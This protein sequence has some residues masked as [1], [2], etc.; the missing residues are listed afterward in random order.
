MSNSQEENDGTSLNNRRGFIFDHLWGIPGDVDL[1]RLKEFLSM[2]Q[3]PY[4][5]LW[6]FACCYN[7][8]LFGT[9]LIA[10]YFL[11]TV[12]KSQTMSNV[13]ADYVGPTS[14][15]CC[16][17]SWGRVLWQFCLNSSLHGV[18]YLVYCS[19][20]F[21]ERFLWGVIFFVAVGVGIFLSIR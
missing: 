1:A 18:R 17:N 7:L 15:I 8:R 12:S 6:Y 5:I 14:Q 4:G 21:I 20:H 13:E 3:V 10:D 9:S 2:R 19:E 11:K 16:D